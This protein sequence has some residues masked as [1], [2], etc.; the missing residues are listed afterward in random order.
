M[1]KHFGWYPP[2]Q[3]KEKQFCQY[4]QI[5]GR[6]DV[7]IS[8]MPYP[9]RF[10]SFRAIIAFDFLNFQLIQDCLSPFHALLLPQTLRS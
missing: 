7:L 8:I 3:P 5:S 2:T 10:D 9:S 6:I 4:L 1:R